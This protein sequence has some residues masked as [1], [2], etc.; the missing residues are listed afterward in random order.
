M[1]NYDPEK[2]RN[3][4]LLSHSGAGKTSLVEAM[5]FDSKAI[6][7]LGTVNDGTTTSDYDPDE[8]K[9]R[10]SINLSLLPCQWKDTKLNLIDTPGYPDF[11][12]EVRA[13]LRVS[14]GA[15]IMVCAASGVEVGTEQAWEFV[16][17]AKIPSLIFVN[18]MDRENANFLNTLEE[19]QTKLDRKCL[20]VQLPIGSE[21]GFKGVVDLVFKKAYDGTSMKEA[22]IPSTMMDMVDS[23]REKLIE[24]VVEVDD[25][26]IARYLDGGEIGQEE[27]YQAV[28]QATTLG[29]VTPVLVGSAL[30]NIGVSQI[31]DAIADYLPSPK[32]KG[33]VK[34]VNP[35]TGAEENV[36]PS[37]TASL[38]TLVFKSSADPYVGKLSY[39]RVYSG[40]I[41][42]NSQIWNA[43]RNVI[44]RIGQLF[45]LRGKNQEPVSQLGPGDI[46][47]VAKLASTTTSD[48][49]TLQA[50]PLNL[51]PVQ[52]PHP[53]IS[54]AVYPKS[55]ADLDKIGTVLP[56][57]CEEDPTL[58]MHREA[59]TKEAL[60]SGMGE[61]HLE[62]AVQRLAHKFG[63]EV[64][65]EVPKVP[66]RETI[67]IRVKAEYKHKK[68]TGGH[69]QY[70]HVLLDMEPLPRGEGFE[71]VNKIVGGSIP[72]NYIPAVEK[73]VNEAKLEGVLAGY[74]VNDIRVMLY[75][76]SFH[77]VD[78]SEIAFKIAAAQAMK[79]GLTQGQPVL[80]EP[81][82]NLTITVP[83]TFTGDIIGDLNTKRAKVLGM[84]PVNGSNVIQAQVPLAEIMRYAIDLRS[85]TQGRGTFI[86]EASHYEEVPA[87][88][89]QKIIAQK[90]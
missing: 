43:N 78:S 70:G 3:T 89:V 13:G 1:Q 63:V 42:S 48:T 47:A 25:Q 71:F 20:P 77:A 18:K 23:Y 82:A 46:G 59:D 26:L 85:I 62:V 10:I 11:V 58:Q 36:E 60:I 5:L 44:E 84:T 30:S 81:I 66:Y 6:N 16:T 22:E 31:L 12:A 65:L 88:T 67:A 61:T 86:T 83:D 38:A 21:K 76:G 34:A 37:P 73:G 80:L 64:I 40:I 51:A 52:F 7:R 56:R 35:S 4:V 55:K 75:D 28:K 57:L 15:V 79:K 74:P 87:A 53:I 17:E 14:E 9:R 54:M 32:E 19:I 45:I 2:I 33:A 68:Q 90:G 8:I 27:I 69:G 39:L 29:K 49:I 50:H 72:K 24:T 41:S